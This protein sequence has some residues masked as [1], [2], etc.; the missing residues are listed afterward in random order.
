MKMEK[1]KISFYLRLVIGLGLLAFMLRKVDFIEL[2]S[3]FASLQLSYLLLALIVRTMD[4]LLTTYRW[5]LLLKT[6]A[7]SLPYWALLKIDFL[8]IF[9]G[10]VLPS[11][12]G[13]DIVRGYSLYKLTSKPAEA[14]SS[15]TVDRLISTL[16]L[17]LIASLC[18]LIYYPTVSQG[19]VLNNNLIIMITFLFIG[20]LIL[21]WNGPFLKRKLPKIKFLEDNKI[22]GKVRVLYRSFLDYRTYKIVLFGV[23]I[24][25]FISQII[26]ILIPYFFSLALGFSIPIVYFFLFIPLIIF[27]SQIPISIGGIGI[28]EGAFLYFFSLIGVSST[29]VLAL[30]I[31]GYIL[32]LVISLPGCILYIWEGVFS[33]APTPVNR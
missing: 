6:K 11:S 3:L 1:G 4:R 13:G 32:M 28:R 31:L 20:I 7:I 12:A 33:G 26:R 10:W 14:I 9:C 24:L 19:G 15:I 5:K 23:L 27:L 8:S 25:A 18:S 21:L 2:N 16:S 17:L 29:E 22:G 30:P